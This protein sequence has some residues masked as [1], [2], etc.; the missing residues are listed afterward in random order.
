[1]TTQKV[2]KDWPQRVKLAARA[3]KTP[4]ERRALMDQVLVM[5]RRSDPMGL[6]HKG[7][8]AER[9]QAVYS[10]QVRNLVRAAA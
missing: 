1:M 4:A 7:M 3:A 6:R 8:D 10:S 5:L 9:R 2:P